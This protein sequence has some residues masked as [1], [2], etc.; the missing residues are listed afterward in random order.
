MA[1]KEPCGSLEGNNSKE[2]ADASVVDGKVFMPCI[3]VSCVSG[4]WS[5]SAEFLP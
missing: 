5:K 4:H 3:E 1:M 2:A